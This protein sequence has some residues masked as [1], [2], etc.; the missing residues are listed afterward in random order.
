ML[1]EFCICKPTRRI[2]IRVLR[3]IGRLPGHCLEQIGSATNWYCQVGN[4]NNRRDAEDTEE[5]KG[6]NIKSY[7]SLRSLCDLRA[8]AVKNLTVPANP[9]EEEVIM[10]HSISQLA[11]FLTISLFLSFA[12]AVM[13]AV[14]EYIVL[15]LRFDEGSGDVAI[16][17]S[18]YGNDGQLAGPKWVEGK[19]GS[20]LLFD[21]IDDYVEVESN[22]TLQLGEEGLTLAA[23]FK[24]E[25][26]V[27]AD[28]M[29]I[30]K[31]PWAPGEY[32]LSYPGYANKRV[33]FQVYDDNAGN[34][35]QPDSKSGVPEL[36]DNE[37][38]YAAATY[39]AVNGV[40][41]IYVDG[42]LETE[43]DAQGGTFIPDDDPVYIGT[44]NNQSLYFSG[45]IDELLVAN[46]PLTAE[47]L[48]KHME[49]TLFSVHPAGNLVTAWGKIKRNGVT[50]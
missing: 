39:D 36:S 45:A 41:K 48:K 40:V 38:H 4:E 35:V 11:L 44:R 50:N 47:Q 5:E 2:L 28:L 14:D 19:Y 29:I 17:S 42:K 9:P 46:V 25:E 34:A 18:N 15:W 33:R 10:R 27:R 37:W 24:T 12:S 20:A 8:S 22:D 7:P 26:T 43:Q 1:A 16:D 21:G 31:G 49:G 3:W 32:A 6:R 13:A 30:E 23:W